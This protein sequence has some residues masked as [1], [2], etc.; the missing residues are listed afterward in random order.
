MQGA[1]RELRLDSHFRTVELLGIG[2]KVWRVER[3]PKIAQTLFKHLMKQIDNR[4]QEEFTGV[5]RSEDLSEPCSQPD[6]LTELL[7]E[8]SIKSESDCV[9][10]QNHFV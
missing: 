6:S 1:K 3:F 5:S 10:T 8:I 9:S 4:M 2:F 7:T